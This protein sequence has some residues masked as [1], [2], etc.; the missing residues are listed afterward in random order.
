MISFFGLHAFVLTVIIIIQCQIYE[1]Y[2]QTVNKI[3]ILIIGGVIIAALIQLYL[4]AALIEQ[5]LDYLYFFSYVKVGVTLLKYIP[6]AYSNYQ[7]KST[8]GWSVGNIILDTTGGVLSFMQV[9]LDGLNTGNWSI[10]EGGGA[11]FALAVISL[12]FDILFLIQHY[13]LYKN[14]REDIHNNEQYVP[15]EQNKDLL[16]Y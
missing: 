5:W 1:S 16:S 4:C 11:K 14:S 9:F 13:C 7:R 10:F 8:T 3:V 2:G 12:A 15:I 6:Q